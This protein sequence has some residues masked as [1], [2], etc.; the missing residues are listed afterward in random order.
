MCKAVLLSRKKDVSLP[1][2]ERAVF[3]FNHAEVGAALLESWNIPETLTNIVRHCY[4]PLSS[5]LPTDSSIVHLATIM[6][7]GLRRKDFCSFHLPDFFSA[8]LDETKISPSVLAPILSQYDRQFADTL[9]ILT[10]GM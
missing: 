7:T 6:A 2:A 5:P 3:G 10:D 9:E 4:T 8:T 1:A